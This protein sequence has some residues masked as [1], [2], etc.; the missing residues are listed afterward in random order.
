MA[1]VPPGTDAGEVTLVF[2]E[3]PPGSVY[4]TYARFRLSGE[5]SFVA[6]PQPT[7]LAVGGE[8]EDY[9][10]GRPTR[11]WDGEAGDNNV[12]NPV[13]WSLRFADGVIT[14]LNSV[15]GNYENVFIDNTFADQT[16]IVRTSG[17]DRFR[18]RS[19][20]SAAPIRIED[21]GLLQINADSQVAALTLD[22]IRTDYGDSL[23]SGAGFPTLVV[24]GDFVWNQAQINRL[25]IDVGGNLIMATDRPHDLLASVL[26]VHGDNSIWSGGNVQSSGSSIYNHGTLTSTSN[27]DSLPPG[28]FSPNAVFVNATGATWVHDAPSDGSDFKD[29]F[30]RFYNDGMLEIRQ[31][32]LAFGDCCTVITH[33]GNVVLAEDTELAIRG[34][35]NRFAAIP[36]S[37]QKRAANFC[38]MAP[39]RVSKEVSM[40]GERSR[41]HPLPVLLHP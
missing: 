29:L 3:V 31:G 7:G 6:D 11:V 20:Q 16:L 40:L 36:P 37:T 22:G 28:P 5:E 32:K 12:L 2:P 15:P 35:R 25:S 27:S 38:S 30:G 17:S 23:A 10:V 13:N 8:V 41:L 9:L 24:D 21:K 34:K 26:H 4:T 33:H 18:V 1:T 19:I 39:V 14:N